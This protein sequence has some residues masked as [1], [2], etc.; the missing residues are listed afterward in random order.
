MVMVTRRVKP[1]H[2]RDYRQWVSRLIAETKKFPNYFGATVIAPATFRFGRLLPHS[3]LRGQKSLSA[4]LGSG[5]ARRLSREADAFSSLGLQHA[6]GMEAWFSLPDALQL[7]PPRKWKMAIATFMG[8]YIVT[9]IAI[10]LE[11]RWY[12]F[13]VLLRNQHH[14]QHHH[15]SGDDLGHHARH[16]PPAAR[17]A[18]CQPG[19]NAVPVP[20]AAWPPWQ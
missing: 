5:V 19:R 13:L 7:P 18:Q 3:Q 15:G 14:H 4:F 12:P 10:P 1:G 2:E 20:A 8:A 9:A 16:E 17:L 11:T 6:T